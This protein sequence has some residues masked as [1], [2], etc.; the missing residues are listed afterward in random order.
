M[1]YSMDH[2]ARLLSLK[3]KKIK[4]NKITSIDWKPGDEDYYSGG[5]SSSDENSLTDENANWEGDEWIDKV[6]RISRHEFEECLFAIIQSNTSDTLFFDH[7]IEFTSCP[8]CTYSIIPTYVVDIKQLPVIIAMDIRQNHGAVVLPKVDL[9]AERKSIHVYVELSSNGQYICPVIGRQNDF[10]VGVKYGTLEHFSEGVRLYAHN[11][12]V[13][14]WDVINAYNIKRFAAG[15]WTANEPVTSSSWQL[16]SANEELEFDFLKRFVPIDRTGNRWIRY[17]SLLPKDFFINFTAE[18][19]KTGAGGELSIS[20][21]KK[22]GT[23]GTIEYLDTRKSTTAFGG[24]DGRD[25][26]SVEIPV[27][28]ERNDEIIPVARRTSGTFSVLSGSSF[29]VIEF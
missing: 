17:T 9:E 12:G 23:D 3:N 27:Q 5:I 6:V 26:I 25:S 18:I 8:N 7:P 20:V 28:L 10:Q 29:K 11:W 22:S 21:A 13:P 2:T 24:G 16:L 14:H 1:G 15:L 19:Q 4:E